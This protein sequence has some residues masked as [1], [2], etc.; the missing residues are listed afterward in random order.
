MKAACRSMRFGSFAIVLSLAGFAFSILWSLSAGASDG[1]EIP[2]DTRI[3]AATVYADRAQVTRTGA[4][5]LK[6]GLYK[7]VCGDLPR[8]FDESSLQ[9]EGKGTARS[10][11][12]GIDVVKVQ[13]LAA[14]SPR[15]KDL[16]GKLDG[17]TARRDTLQIE[18]TALMSSAHFLDDFA[19]LPSIREARSSPS[20]YSA[21]KTGR[22]SS[23]FSLPSASERTRRSA[24]S[25]NESRS[26]PRR[27]TGSR[28]S[29]TKCRRRTTGAGAS[30][31]TAR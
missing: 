5:E 18:H 20:R 23:I 29:S 6:A 27:S 26:S 1:K 2:L 13:G 17:L 4:V 25:P 31:S 30:S 14:D 28:A 12:M 9:V 16:K 3:A 22:T 19:K 11:I 21:C 7:L 10:R 24:A 15:Y 8:S